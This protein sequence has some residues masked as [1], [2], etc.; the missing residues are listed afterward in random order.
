M[1]KSVMYISMFFLVLCVVVYVVSFAMNYHNVL[2]YSIF[3]MDVFGI[4]FVFLYY[5][6]EIGKYEK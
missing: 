1:L 5:K 3:A 6:Y 4:L 2:L